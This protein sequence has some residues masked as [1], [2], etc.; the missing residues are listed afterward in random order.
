MKKTF[1]L[2]AVLSLVLAFYGQPA[3]ANLLTNG[4]F[5]NT[6]GFVEN[7]GGYMSLDTGSTAITGWTVIQ[8]ETI[9]IGPAFKGYCS[10]FDGSYFLDLTGRHDSVPFGGVQQS[11]NTVSGASYL[12]EFDLGSSASYG[13]PS[14]II[15]SAGS[16]SQTFTSTNLSSNNVWEDFALPFMASSGITT[17]SFTGSTGSAGSVYI[18]LDNVTVSAVPIPPGV[19]LLGAGLLPLAAYRRRKLASRT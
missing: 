18:G 5:E 7:T 13:L 17:I 12:L 4:S 19:W 6:T 3:R 9:W 8:A 1:V 16:I 14:S 15:A 10:A 2:L 11:I